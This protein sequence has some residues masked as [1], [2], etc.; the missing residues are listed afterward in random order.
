MLALLASLLNAP[1]AMA[2]FEQAPESPW[3]QGGVASCVFPRSPM[4]LFH[5]P[6][7]LG[8]LE[9]P[10]ASASAS[11]PFGLRRL[12][13]VALA[14]GMMWPAATAGAGVSL[15]GDG[16]YTEATIGTAFAWRIRGGLALGLGGSVR[17]LRISSYGRATG[18][19]ADMGAVWSPANGV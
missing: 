13:R 16:S 10:G 15:T 14:G 12:D 1:A 19:S 5:N 6:A 8:L 17:L 9:G 7:S 2:A 3:L 4:T 11:R 18:F